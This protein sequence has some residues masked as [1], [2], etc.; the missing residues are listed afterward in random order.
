MCRIYGHKRRDGLLPIV[1]LKTRSY[2]H[3]KFGRIETPEFAIV[4][5]DG[6]VP[7]TAAA[8]IPPNGT[9]ATA[10]DMDDAIPF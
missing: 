7:Q 5:W 6:G 3:K 2:K 1:A 9:A 4:G 8:A 10:A